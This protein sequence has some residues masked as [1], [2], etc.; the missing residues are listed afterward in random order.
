MIGQGDV[1]FLD[2]DDAKSLIAAGSAERL[3][4][5]VVF[6]GDSFARQNELW[7]SSIGPLFEGK[8]NH[9]GGY[10]RL[11]TISEN[12]DTFGR[13]LTTAAYNG[14]TAVQ[15]VV[16]LNPDVILVT[17]DYNDAA[18]PVDG[19]TISEAQNN[20]TA[21]FESLKSALPNAKIYYLA[22][23]IY[24]DE[25]F[26]PATLKNKGIAP[27]DMVLKSSGNYQGFYYD[28]IL[29][30]SAGTTIRT[31]YANHDTLQAHVAGLSQVD[32]VVYLDLWKAARMGYL[33]PD[34]IHFSLAGNQLLS[35]DI[36]LKFQSLPTVPEFISNCTVNPK[37]N[38]SIIGN[39]FSNCLESDGGDGWQLKSNGPS[40]D[41]LQ[42]LKNIGSLPELE[43]WYMPMKGQFEFKSKALTAGTTGEAVFSWFISSAYPNAEVWVSIDLVSSG[44][45]FQAA[46]ATDGQNIYTNSQGDA[47]DTGLTGLSAATYN[48]RFIVKPRLST[49]APIMFQEFEVVV[50]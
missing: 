17:S 13:M 42:T 24:D 19:D 3:P 2:D 35:G 8:V 26:T 31:N 40:I 25:N 41:V 9:S 10:I 48:V 29:D 11:T 16:S 36:L 49:D 5:N 7:S 12:A 28:G 38:W 14:K 23:K 50:S 37:T 44:A 20:A 39:I 4:H 43:N 18:N 21:V 6:F 32:G 33:D 45:P 46:N 27:G 22:K 30:D 15:E 34:G 1:L 47:F